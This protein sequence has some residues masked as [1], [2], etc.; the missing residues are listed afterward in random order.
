MMGEELIPYFLLHVLLY[1][2]QSPA[3]FLVILGVGP[4]LHL[5]IP[6]MEQGGDNENLS[7]PPTWV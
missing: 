4:P 7:F 5:R 1:S 6:T 3:R 2:D